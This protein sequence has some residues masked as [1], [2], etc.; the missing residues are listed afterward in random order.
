MTAWLRRVVLNFTDVIAQKHDVDT[1]RIAV[2]LLLQET[3][4]LGNTPYAKVALAR[5]NAIV[6][7]S[8][9]DWG[10]STTRL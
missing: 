7:A 5:A 4:R 1:D 3:Q 9:I 6:P 10:D 2:D 8:D